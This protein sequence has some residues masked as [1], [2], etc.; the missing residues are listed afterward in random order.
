MLS[1]EQG[2]KYQL[3]LTCLTLSS[4]VYIVTSILQTTSILWFAVLFT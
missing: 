4:A 1:Y 2:T 3:T